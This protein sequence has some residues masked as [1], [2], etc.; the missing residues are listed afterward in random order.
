[1]SAPHLAGS[2]GPISVARCHSTRRTQPPPICRIAQ[3]RSQPRPR[4]AQCRRSAAWGGLCHADLPNPIQSPTCR[5]ANRCLSTTPIPLFDRNGHPF[6]PTWRP[7]ERCA[8]ARS[9]MPLAASAHPARSVLDGAEHSAMLVDEGRY[10]PPFLGGGYRP[11]KM[12]DHWWGVPPDQ[13][14][15]SKSFGAMPAT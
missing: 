14:S 1:M 9:R 5:Q 11:A 7:P 13:V 2:C 4:L 12:L 8:Q 6:V 15:G 3:A 10:H